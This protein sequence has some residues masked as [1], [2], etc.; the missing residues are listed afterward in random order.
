[1]RIL[2]TNDDGIMAPGLKV[3]EEIA[4]SIA[5][6]PQKVVTVAPALEQSGVGHCISYVRPT[7]ITEVSANRFSVEGSPADCVLAGVHYVMKDAPPDLIISGVNK[8]HNLADDILY[9]GTVGAALEG[10]L[11]N[12]NSIALSQCYS[13]HSLKTKDPFE[14]A[15]AHGA[16]ICSQIC[17]NSFWNREQYKIFYNVNFPA[18]RGSEV[19]GVKVCCKGTRFPGSFSMDKTKAPNGR[20]FLWVNHRPNKESVEE[21]SDLYAIKHGKISI[22]PLKADFTDHKTITLLDRNISDDY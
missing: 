1:M 4:L 7:L 5:K 20:V 13:K 19:L 2:V 22:T 6:D 14:A 8:G 12:I 16:R 18:V 21:D 11:Q 17:E 10:A 3:A 15:R 9:S